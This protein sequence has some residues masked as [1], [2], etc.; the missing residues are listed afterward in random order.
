MKKILLP[1][2]ILTVAA[3]AG[4]FYIAGDP[5][6]NKNN[7]H[8]ESERGVAGALEY[9]SRM[10]GNAQ[11][12][13]VSPDD[14]F[15]ARKKADQM[16]LAKS[17]SAILDWEFIG[18]NNIG[19]R[20][21][22]ILIDRN[23]TNHLLAGSVSG[24]LWVSFDGGVNWAEHPFNTDSPCLAVSCIAQAPNGDIYIGTGEKIA[25]WSTDFY[26]TG[27]SAFPGCG[28]YKSTDGGN[29]FSL[30]SST[31]PAPN[32]ANQQ[33]AYVIALDTHP[34]NE[35]WIYAT[36]ER[37]LYIS[38]D[39][40]NT[41]TS[42]EG[43]PNN[44]GS[45]YDVK[46][47][48]NGHVHA[49]VG[50]RYLKSTDGLTFVNK[51]G[52]NL[53]DFPNIG[54]N[55][56]LAVAP[57]NPNYIYAVTI[58][59]NGCLRQ[60]LQS[61]NGGDVWVEIGAGVNGVFNPLGTSSYCQ[62]WYDLCIIAD[63]SNPERIFVGGL[64]LWSWSSTDNWQAVTDGSESYFNPYYVHVDL[65]TLTY[66][67]TDP[68][69]I[70]IGCDGG[71]FRTTNATQNAPTWKALNKNYNVTQF[72]AIAAG[73]D[74][75]VLGGTQDNG[76]I[77]TSFDTD[78]YFA[79]LDVT[80]GDGGFTD[81]SKINPDVMFA[82]NQEGALR[83]SPNGGESFAYGGFLDENIDCQPT[84]ANGDCD[85]DGH[86][87]NNPLFI[88]PTIL[89]E[90][91]TTGLA[92]YATGNGVGQVWMTIEALNVSK[93]PHWQVVGTFT[94]GGTVSSVSIARDPS[95]KVMI[96]AGST[97]GRV[98]VLRNVL[99][100]EFGP[101]PSIA[102]ISAINR[103][104]F[105]VSEITG[106][107]SGRYVTSVTSNPGNP[108]EIVV[109]MGNYNNNNYVFRT[110]NAFSSSATFTSI[111]GVGDNALPPMPVYSLVIDADNPNRLFAGTDLGVWMCDIV[112]TG[113]STYEYTWSEQNNTIGRIP[114]FRIR[115][116]P[117]K[118]QGCNVL[119]IGTH[120]KGFFRSTTLTFPPPNCDTSLP[121]WGNAV[122][123]GQADQ[124]GKLNVKI[125]PNPVSKTG[126]IMVE[127]P[128]NY[129]KTANLSVKIFNLMGQQ[130]SDILFSSG[131]GEV[132]AIP[133]DVTKLSA[134]TYLAVVEMENNRISSR[135]VVQ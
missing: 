68:N 17:G 22:A 23:N 40:G 28:I 108:Q 30:L 58:F 83:R 4:Y 53:G 126:T 90:D 76:T 98:M 122:G 85:S 47:A 31:Q 91:L 67:P 81:I 84:Q 123:T 82:A 120:G 113:V 89:Y 33:W 2:F 51:S 7:P 61:S 24:G 35:G 1:L 65:H 109:T 132:Q 59:P 62:G 104:I 8:K 93:V 97:G 95:G 46:V 56:K 103:K 54:D 110:T 38:T 25:G 64:T 100:D 73:Y 114:V 71:V 107:S 119:Y 134:G 11:T 78:S 50:S 48:S 57:S 96:L 43:I 75:R 115:Q 45:G 133:L 49:L 19:G 44:S 88:T 41:W 66:H 20:T 69:I 9:L 5:K 127:L 26:G 29:T 99:V 34:T 92:V 15:R 18:P 116:E 27:N 13:E 16:Q 118:Q 106:Q 3:A 129:T 60:V 32:N 6:N 14:V 52:S 124:S 12:G 37:S 86:V 131:N 42:P 121:G 94:G 135:F 117:I 39:G 125:A 80:G 111:Q 112:Q 101:N 128:A 70:Y 55:K 77:F 87:D 79:G 102:A 74:G 21:R 130:V 63:P 72:Y 105:S 10:R 36:T